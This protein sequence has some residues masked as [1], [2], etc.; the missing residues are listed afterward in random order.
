MVEQ[1]TVDT[2]FGHDEV[3][4]VSSKKQIENLLEKFSLIDYRKRIYL[5]HP[6]LSEI[7][8]MFFSVFNLVIAGGGLVFNSKN[9]L[10][11]IL[12]NGY[13]DLP[14]G[15]IEK[16]ESIQNGAVREVEEETQAK[17]KSVIKRAGNT[18]HT[19]KL[20]EKRMLKETHWFVMS[21]K[22][23]NLKP[24]KEEGIEAVKWI[25]LDDLPMCY[26]HCYLNVKSIIQ[27]ALAD[28]VVQQFLRE[29]TF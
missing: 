8:Q 1:Y 21:G 3:I 26:D 13:W 24:Q 23:K 20:K 29:Q 12:R 9:Q 11:M 18:F 28:E 27:D 6:D 22:G 25:S 4:S 16:G 7:K 15:K 17:V 14:K 19:Y 2:V 5:L 10:L